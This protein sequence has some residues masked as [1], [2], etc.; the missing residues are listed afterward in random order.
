MS[1]ARSLFRLP[2][3]RGFSLRDGSLVWTVDH[4]IDAAYDGAAGKRTLILGVMG[5]ASSVAPAR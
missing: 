2:T 4:Y 3:D 5:R 1:T